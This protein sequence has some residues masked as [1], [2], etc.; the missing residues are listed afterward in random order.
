MMVPLI[1]QNL[2]ARSSHA[3]SSFLLS[4]ILTILPPFLTR[5]LQP[6]SGS[7]KAAV[8]DRRNHP[9]TFFDEVPVVVYCIDR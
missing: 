5:L 6:P 2:S 8:C 3:Y 7:N 1:V 4:S 9:L